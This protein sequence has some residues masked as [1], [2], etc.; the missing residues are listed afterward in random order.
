MKIAD[1]GDMIRKNIKINNIT[2]KINTALEGWEIE[3]L[4]GLLEEVKNDSIEGINE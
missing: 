3:Q 4:K 2:E 1:V